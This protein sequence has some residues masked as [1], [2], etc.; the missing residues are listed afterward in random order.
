MILLHLCTT[1]SCAFPFAK[2]AHHLNYAF[3]G[4]RIMAAKPPVSVQDDLG[5]FD[6][7]IINHPVMDHWP[8]IEWSS[9]AGVLLKSYMQV[10]PPTA[11]QIFKRIACFPLLSPLPSSLFPLPSPLF[12]LFSPLSSPLS[13]LSSLFSPLP[14]SFF[15]LPSLQLSSLLSS[16]SSPL[17]L[18]PSLLSPL[19]SP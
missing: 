11:S 5:G 1:L 10:C 9:S 6:M 8:K 12:R 7:D 14:S 3:R 2:T 16:P 15:P 4:Q 17:S 19:P 18:L 13:L